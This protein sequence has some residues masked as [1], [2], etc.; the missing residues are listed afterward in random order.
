M[1]AKA[2][3]GGKMLNHKTI[4]TIL[5]I[6]AVCLIS[7]A[8]AEEKEGSKIELIPV[9]EKT[10]DDTIRD[11]IYDEVEMTVEQARKIGRNYCGLNDKQKIKLLYPK[12]IVTK[13]NIQFCDLLGN[14]KRLISRKARIKGKEAYTS[15]VI[16]DNGKFVG[17][18]KSVFQENIGLTAILTIYDNEGKLC[19]S[20]DISKVGMCSGGPYISPNG[21]YVV[22]DGD[23]SY[24]YCDYWP[25]IY[26]KDGLRAELFPEATSPAYEC[27]I[28]D[29]IA[30]TPDGSKFVVIKTNHHAKNAD[31]I[32]FTSDGKKIWEKTIGN[33]GCGWRS[34]KISKSGRYIILCVSK[35]IKGKVSLLL[36]DINGNLIWKNDDI[37]VGTPDFMF[38]EDEK[39]LVYINGWG[40]LYFMNLANGKVLWQID[41]TEQEVGRFRT[42]SATPDLELLLIGVYGHYGR[43]D[44]IYIFNKKGTLLL[45]QEFESGIFHGAPKIEIS[46]DGKELIMCRGKMIKVEQI[47]QNGR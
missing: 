45:E 25:S 10:F 13:S 11:V 22:A 17:M 14:P 1:P 47:R 12:I 35:G 27:W 28:N 37:K 30:F 23:A 4:K 31:L 16:S 6:T 40:L 18:V 41:K 42:L 39:S 15:V 21:E 7:L 19:W 32:L 34:V 9:Y 20:T 2:G 24:D 26:D 3:K 33:G 38:S 43:P 36:F 8:R 44:R 29:Q 5:T 46:S